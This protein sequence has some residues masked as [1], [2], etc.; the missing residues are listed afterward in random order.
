MLPGVL[1]AGIHQILLC[2]HHWHKQ[3]VQ[4]TDFSGGFAAGQTIRRFSLRRKGKRKK[5]KGNL[6]PETPEPV[7]ADPFAGHA[8]V[9]ERGARELRDIDP[10]PAA[11]RLAVFTIVA[12]R[13]FPNVP[14]HVIQAISIR[15]L[16][17][18]FMRPIS[19]IPVIPRYPI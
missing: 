5:N 3:N 15:S 10:G 8:P 11:Q 9:T 13:P 1:A 14:Q 6:I 19:T 7:V 2:L 12:R 4:E 16:P 18:Y 17:F